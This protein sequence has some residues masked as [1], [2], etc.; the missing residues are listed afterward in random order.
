MVTRLVFL[1]LLFLAFVF[2]A[3]AQNLK[4]QAGPVIEHYGAVYDI[5]NP[6]FP[7]DP[8]QVFKVVFD[9]YDSPGGPEALNVQ[10]NTIA[11]FLNMHARAG[12]PV[13]HMQVAAVLHGG[14][15][16]DAL[17]NKGYRKRFGIDNPNLGIIQELHEAGVRFYI[18][19]QSAAKR[20]FAREELAEPVGVAL[21]AMTVLLQLQAKGYK[22]M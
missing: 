19:G 2:C 9:V 15:G 21:S 17:N 20:G 6:D 1:S 8:E 12:M 5:P 3:D 4:A 18:C 13:E 7:A 22:T 10:L 16:K 11:R 14:A